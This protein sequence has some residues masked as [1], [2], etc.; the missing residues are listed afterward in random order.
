MLDLVIA[1]FHDRVII[2]EKVEVEVSVEGREETPAILS[3]MG[4]GKIKVLKAR[5]RELIE[6]L[7]NDFNIGAGEAEALALA[8]QEKAHMVATDDRNAIRA[9]KALKIDFVTAVAF[10]LRAFEKQLIDMD[11]AISKI[12]KL[13]SIGRYSKAIIED[14]IEQIRKGGA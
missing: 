9:C 2:P 6:K 11:E 5:G 13:Q 4:E 7:G 14:A 1:D 8:L 10:V 3:L 12:K